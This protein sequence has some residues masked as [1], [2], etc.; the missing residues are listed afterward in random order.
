[1]WQS[2]AMTDE[3]TSDIMGKATGGHNKVNN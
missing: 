1:M 3:A 2:L